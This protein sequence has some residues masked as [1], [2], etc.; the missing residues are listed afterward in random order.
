MQFNVEKTPFV[1]A[2]KKLRL[3]YIRQKAFL[4]CFATLD[5]ITSID[6]SSNFTVFRA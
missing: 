6:I 5:F 3:R 2:T 4:E 1:A